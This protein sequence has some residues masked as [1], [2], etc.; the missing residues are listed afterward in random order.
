MGFL[1]GFWTI[2][3]LLVYLFNQFSLVL[4]Q[5]TVRNILYELGYRCRRPRLAASKTDELFSLKMAGLMKRLT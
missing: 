1:A 4:S 5:T 3:L 2:P